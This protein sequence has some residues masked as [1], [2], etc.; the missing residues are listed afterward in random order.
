[1]QCHVDLKR[2]DGIVVPLAELSREPTPRRG[3]IIL[4]EVNG[5]T[6]R[7]R[8]DDVRRGNTISRQSGVES[9]CYITATEL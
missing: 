8:V 4:V 1:M 2:K 5:T 9:V 7:A 6:V 3:D